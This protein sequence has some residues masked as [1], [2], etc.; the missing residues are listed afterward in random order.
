MISSKEL[1]EGQDAATMSQDLPAGGQTTPS[2]GSAAPLT[3]ALYIYIYICI[4]REREIER[5]REII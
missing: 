1:G 5:A 3:E 2:V 4:E